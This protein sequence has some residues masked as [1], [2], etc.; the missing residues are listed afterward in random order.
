MM[1][2]ESTRGYLM[3]AVA[4]G[5]WGTLGLLFKVLHDDYGIAVLTL[6]FLRAGGALVILVAGLA[7]FR[8]SLL[9][10]SRRSLVFFAIYGLCGVSAFYIS[11][12][13]AVVQ[14]SVTTAVVLL[15]TAPAFVTLLA[16]RIWNES[17]GT[18]KLVALGLAFVGCALVARAYDPSQLSVNLIGLGF[19]VA[20]G[21]T[22][23]LYTI[24]SK[25]ALERHESWTALAYALF[26]GALFLLPLQTWEGFAPLRQP[27]AWI[28]VVALA[29]GPTLGS[30]ALYNAGLRRVPASN[31]SVTATIE[32]VVASVL[33]FLFL[34]ERLELL[35]LVGAAMV[36]AGAVWLSAGEP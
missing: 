35:Q 13:E 12:I 10:I 14:T 7:L 19:G 20:A 22:Y 5:L 11:Y 36:V 21:F 2:E 1:R 6:A 23:A 34:G 4:A 15:Y 28:F 29:A 25:S 27:G 33:A 26:F 17:L 32:P 30:L 18:R 24:F 16:W 3:V 31:A 8:P 9:S